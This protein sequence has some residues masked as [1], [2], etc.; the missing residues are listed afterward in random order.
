MTA[1]QKSGGYP[2]LFRLESPDGMACHHDQQ[3]HENQKKC[4]VV[5]QFFSPPS[6]VKFVH[7]PGNDKEGRQKVE[8]DAQLKLSEPL[9]NKEGGAESHN[10]QVFQPDMGVA[11]FARRCRVRS[12]PA[13]ARTVPLNSRQTYNIFPAGFFMVTPLHSF[14]ADLKEKTGEDRQVKE[15][16]RTFPGRS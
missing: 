2:I 6:D 9:R 3:R 12:T 10:R 14:R 1:A 11:P 15:C 7:Q 5:A 13:R 8:T 16:S 4:R